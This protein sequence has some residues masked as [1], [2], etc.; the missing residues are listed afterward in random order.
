V[1][2]VEALQAEANAWTQA[3]LD[4]LAIAAPYKRADRPAD[5]R[6]VEALRAAIDYSRMREAHYL[7]AITIVKGASQ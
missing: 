1:N 2:A 3:Y 5:R 7:N 6:V 4:L